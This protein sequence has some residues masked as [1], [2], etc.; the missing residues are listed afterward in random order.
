[1]I[2]TITICGGGS[3]GHAIAGVWGSKE[4]VI[5]NILSNRA[6]QWEKTITV[7]DNTNK[8]YCGNIN[9]CTSS[10]ELVIPQSDIVLLCVPGFLIEQ[11]LKNIVPYLSP[12]T[13]VGACVGSSG[14]FFTAENVLN[15]CQPLFAFQRVPY[16]ARVC[17]YGKSGRILGHKACLNIGF[18]NLEDISFLQLLQ[19]NLETPVKKLDSYY[20][21]AFSNSNPIL[22]PSRLYGLWHDWTEGMFYDEQILFYESWDDFSSEILIACDNDF[23]N[24]IRH[25]PCSQN[26]IP[27][28]LDYYESSNAHQLSQKLKSIKAFK[29]IFAP[30]KKTSQGFIPD[31]DDRYFKEDIPFGMQ[32]IKNMALKV[33]QKTPAIDQILHWYKQ[34][35]EIIS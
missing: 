13:Y 7:I 16:I 26:G 33:S 32:I 18:K 34:H 8:V 6:E 9:C 21:A 22:H 23:F 29:G 11:T 12:Q 19:T 17:E 30:M 20:D 2:K 35:T 28:L 4:N 24:V 27:R 15:S 3:I 5:V 25:Y 10:P 14:F 31:W 1:M